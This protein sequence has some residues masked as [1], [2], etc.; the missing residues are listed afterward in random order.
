MVKFTPVLQQNQYKE[1]QRFTAHFHMC[2]INRVIP[3]DK[4]NLQNSH[5]ILNCE[6]MKWKANEDAH[7][8][9]SNVRED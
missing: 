4:S 9:L 2:H 1:I 5:N 7:A 8:Y 6:Y 3:T